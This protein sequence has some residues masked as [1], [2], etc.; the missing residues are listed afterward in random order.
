[1]RVATEIVLNEEEQAVLEKIVRS[2]LSSV[3]LAQRAQI[4]LLA[5]EGKQNKEIAQELEV[6][7]VQVSRWRSRYC[8][9]GLGGIKQDLP[10]A[11]QQPLRL[12]TCGSRS[13][14]MY[15][16]SN[17]YTWTGLHGH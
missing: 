2:K 13:T 11:W 8:E 16:L 17:T 5:N 7:R 6:G 1:M 9:F 15:M 4:V 10:R 3:R 14:T 12:K